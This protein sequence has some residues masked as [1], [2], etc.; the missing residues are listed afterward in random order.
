MDRRFYSTRGLLA[1]V[2]LAA[3]T[4][5]VYWP[6]LGFGFINYDDSDYVTQNPRV[7]A[8]LTWPGVVW[9]LTRFHSCN[10]HPVTWWSHMLDWQLFGAQAGAHHAINLLFHVVNALLV[11]ALLR[12][13]TGGF[14]HS[15][16]VA[17]LFALHP[18]QVETVAWV[19]E[20]KNLLSAL[21]GLLSLWAYTRYAGS[22]IRALWWYATG[23]LCFAF[24]LMSK[25]MVVTL[26]FLLLLLDWWPLRRLPRVAQRNDGD[27]GR[28]GL[29]DGL[30]PLVVEKV[31][32][33]A[34][35]LF[36]GVVTLLAQSSGGAVMPMGAVALS[37]RLGNAVV[38]YARYAGKTFWPSHLAAFYPHPGAWPF[39]RVAGAGLA[40]LIITGGVLTQVRKRPALKLGWFWFL[41]ALVPVIGVVQAGYQS[42][43]DRYTYFPLIGLFLAAVFGGTEIAGASGRAVWRIPG[44]GIAVVVLGLCAVLTRSQLGYWKDSEAL[45]AHTLEVTPEN[46]FSH[47]YFGNAL[48]QKGELAA[49]IT[50][51]EKAAQLNPAWPDVHFSL[52]YALGLGMDF[53]GAAAQYRLALRYSPQFL[54]ALNNLAWMLASCSDGRVRDGTEAIK[55]AELACHL[56]GFKDSRSVGTFAAALA[57]AGRFTEATDMAQK[58]NALALASGDQALAQTHLQLLKIYRSGQP[59]HEPVGPNQ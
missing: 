11:F 22:K 16:V 13:W 8:G 37:D 52:G 3:S 58:A 56:T 19:S 9:A 48:V 39:W 43:A 34:L 50:H 18:L 5:A 14:W 20:R 47:F 1:C 59:Y 23:L 10:W 31:P 57:E 6:A 29:F 21:F 49:G 27:H 17:G 42:I 41:G 46:A 24:S 54:S 15:V 32:F 12:Q 45:F 4:A 55:L 2:G 7:Q 53:G 25:P 38:A 30:R 28:Q 40:L 51:L 26:P 33:F 35:S 36:S 44:I